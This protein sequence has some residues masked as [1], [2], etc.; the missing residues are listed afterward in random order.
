MADMRPSMVRM[1]RCGMA[2]VAT[3]HSIIS[4]SWMSMS[5]SVTTNTL[6][7]A[8]Y[9]AAAYSVCHG[10]DLVLRLILMKQV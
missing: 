6:M 5:S 7:N 10:S 9:A 2:R 8:S 3:A 4:G 1:S